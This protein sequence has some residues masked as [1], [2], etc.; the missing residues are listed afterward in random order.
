MSEEQSEL[1]PGMQQVQRWTD[2]EEPVPDLETL[3]AFA[4]DAG[5]RRTAARAVAADTGKQLKALI[6]LMYRA[7][8]TNQYRLAELLQTSRPTVSEALEKAGIA[9]VKA[10]RTDQLHADAS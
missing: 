6:P 3:T 1:S 5:E 9:S 2:G 7:G 4:T 10:K 8:L